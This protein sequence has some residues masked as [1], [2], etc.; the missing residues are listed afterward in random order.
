VENPPY[1]HTNWDT[2]DI[3]QGKERN[4]YVPKKQFDSLVNKIELTVRDMAPIISFLNSLNDDDFDK[5]IP[6]EVPSGLPVGG[7]IQ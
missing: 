1:R 3:S 5:H 2:T 4:P 7:N 6:E